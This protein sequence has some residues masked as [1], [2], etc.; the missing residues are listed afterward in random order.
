MLQGPPI[1]VSGSSAPCVYRRGGLNFVN[2]VLGE[3]VSRSESPRGLAHSSHRVLSHLSYSR[4]DVHGWNSDCLVGVTGGGGGV[5]VRVRRGGC[6]V[7]TRVLSSFASSSA[8]N[9]VTKDE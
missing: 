9:C 8:A 5:G 7:P 1:E 4:G 3:I 6:E 2:V